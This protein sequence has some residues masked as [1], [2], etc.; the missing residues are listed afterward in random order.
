M[1]K[2]KVPDAGERSALALMVDGNR[3]QPDH[4]VIGW[5]I[6]RKGRRD[7]SRKLGW[8]RLC[9]TARKPSQGVIDI[10]CPTSSVSSDGLW[11][12]ADVSDYVYV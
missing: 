3:L 8:K 2:A 12:V 1:T 10:S 11:E 7:R 6:A 5:K 4:D 9:F